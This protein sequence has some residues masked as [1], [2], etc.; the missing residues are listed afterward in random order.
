M[1]LFSVSSNVFLMK[2]KRKEID[3]ND[4]DEVISFLLERSGYAGNR[5]K[6]VNKLK[7]LKGKKCK[8]RFMPVTHRGQEPRNSQ[9]PSSKFRGGC[10]VRIWSTT[11]GFDC[12]VSG[13]TF[14][15]QVVISHEPGYNVK[16]NPLLLGLKK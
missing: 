14:C 7:E 1:R 8:I 6:L 2:N 15:A 5:E 10:L 4:K 12:W 9:N 11:L 3:L 16:D 13:R